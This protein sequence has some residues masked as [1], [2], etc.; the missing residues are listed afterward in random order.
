MTGRLT[1]IPPRLAPEAFGGMPPYM[2]THAPV[3]VLCE[4]KRV[5]KHA[6]Q[7]SPIKPTHTYTHIHTERETHTHTHVH[8]CLCKI[9]EGGGGGGGEPPDEAR[10]CPDLRPRSIRRD[11][12]FGG[13]ERPKRGTQPCVLVPGKRNGEVP[14][15]RRRG[16]VT[17]QQP[18]QQRLPHAV[19]RGAGESGCCAGG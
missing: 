15:R 13:G 3:T 16:R 9:G 8:K 19:G 11:V 6:E 17:G 18:A 10:H 4:G 14:Q 7:T 2:F 1:R 12:N 5:K